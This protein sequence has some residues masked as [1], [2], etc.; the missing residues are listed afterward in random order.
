MPGMLDLGDILQL[1]DDRF[2]DGSFSQQ[3]LVGH[4]HQAVL[5]ILAQFGDELDVEIQPQLLHQ[6]LGDVTFVAKQL[7]EQAFGQCRDW[8]AIINVARGQLAGQ[9]LTLIVDHQV[10]L[11]A[12]K[13][14]H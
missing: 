3:D 6:L 11:E 4:E 9:Q 5:H 12:V 13:P 1:I 2:D 14:T 8:F 10:K 7:A